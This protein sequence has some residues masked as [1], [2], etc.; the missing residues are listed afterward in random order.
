MEQ[1]L[2]NT[3]LF[4]SIKNDLIF[5]IGVSSTYDI[6]EHVWFYKGYNKLHTDSPQIQN[7]W[8]QN[9]VLLYCRRARSCDRPDT[10]QSRVLTWLNLSHKPP[11]MNSSFLKLKSLLFSLLSMVNTVMAL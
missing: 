1:L 5:E 8:L 2:T 4:I 9:A 10:E 6:R 7:A 3:L 11:P